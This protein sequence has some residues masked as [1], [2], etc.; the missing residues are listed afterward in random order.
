[1]VGRKSASSMIGN[2]KI[3]QLRILAQ[4]AIFDAALRLNE[5]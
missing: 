3:S 1:M 4:N 2:E 5:F